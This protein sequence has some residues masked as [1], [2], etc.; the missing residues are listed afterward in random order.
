LTRHILARRAMSAAAALLLAG[1]G[2]AAGSADAQAGIGLFSCRHFI[3]T[4]LVTN[5]DDSGGIDSRSLLIFSADGAFQFIDS[6]QGGVESE[7]NPFTTAAG[8]WTCDRGDRWSRTAS[9]VALDFTLPGTV[10]EDQMIARLDFFDMS[11]DWHT[12][13]IAGM[14]T[15]RFFPLDGD[16]LNP[17]PSTEEPFAFDGERVSGQAQIPLP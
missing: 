16:P 7:Y 2:A 3:G 4:Y 6:N 10:A 14:A 11:V 1:L 5:P 12:G 13:A 17:P 15:L 9:A 8:R